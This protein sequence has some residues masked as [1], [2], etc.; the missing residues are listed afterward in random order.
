[1]VTGHV[2]ESTTRLALPGVTIVVNGTNF[3]TT[4]NEDGTFRLAL[5]TGIHALRFS[6]VGYEAHLDSVQITQDEPFD[7]TVY[8]NP[9][10]IELGDVV[11]EDR[12]M[13]GAGI[14]QLSPEDVQS[15]PTPFKGFQA[16]AVLPGVAS[17]N[18]LS[19]QYSVRGGG[20][21]ENLLF[22]NGFE[23]HM[24][25]RPRQG[26]QEGLGLLNP[27]LAR[28][29]TLH[30]G[31]FSAR[32][33]GKISSSL[34]IEYGA[35]D[36]LST[37][38]SISLLDASVAATA[39][40]GPV[41][42]IIGAR[43][44]QARR[45]FSTQE[46]KGNYHPDYTDVQS[47]LQFALTN[48]HTLE[49]IG[50]WADHSFA[51]D[52]RSRRT[53]FGTV[54]A[55]GGESDLR[56]VWIRYGDDSQEQDGYTTQL[57]GLR[58]SSALS[59]KWL[60]EHDAAVFRTRET[61]QYDLVGNTIIYDVVTG[62]DGENAMIPR[63]N[64][65]QEDRAN[66]EVSVSTYTG[67]GRYILLSSRHAAEIG[68]HIRRLDFEDRIQERST[69]QGRNLE[70]DPVSIVVDSVLGTVEFS[71]SQLGFHAQDAIQLSPRLLLTSGLRADYFSFNDEW[72]W[73]PRLSMNYDASEL[74]T[75]AG[76]IGVYYQTPT[77]RELRGSP[78]AG[79]VEIEALNR[80]IRS[81]RSLQFVGGGE[82]FI[83]TRRIYIRAEA[84]LKSIS[85]V[86]S[87]SVENVR[88]NYSGKND[89]EARVYGID[90]QA[91][92]EI[93]PGMESWIN[94]GLLVAR[95]RFLTEY[96]TVNNEGWIPRPTDQRHSIALY[97]QDY[98]PTDTSWKLHIRALFGSGLPYTPPEEGKQVGSV[99]T[100]IPGRRLAGRYPSF[101]RMDFGAT[102]QISFS[103]F[104]VDLTAELL[105][106]FDITNTVAYNWVP[107]V[108]G[109]WQR[110]PTRLTPRTLN[111]RIRA[112]L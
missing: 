97:I 13:Q 72:V 32:Y 6:F 45:F 102:K 49:L 89:A 62:P 73:S 60:F 93:V 64:A 4:S 10:V 78:A 8:M 2:Y 24:P 22:L 19:N 101:R 61:E 1:M 14:Q 26:E 55:S 15:M 74:L 57:A 67:Q 77:Y 33:G 27:D 91:R 48:T 86:I 87:Y 17:S 83:P 50:V 106:I 95:E 92:G 59:T 18:E 80:D 9:T 99:V 30:T 75:L 104:T 5:P 65:I 94:Y 71:E 7:L 40:S 63:G 36:S 105:N 98:I 41:K 109:I 103:G 44:A 68:W 110:I 112:F 81:Q 3:G 47:L 54:S 38:A 35:A 69:V 88:I 56:S 31:G 108:E 46:L 42:W 16:L 96:S 79:T 70:G 52:P 76:A 37:S 51:L 82:L 34:D 25:F 111:V 12:G 11:V 100:Q 29:I 20:F 85:D 43:K 107:N 28:R 39:T 84:Y 58:L 23:I 21:N 53:Y 90:L 66:N